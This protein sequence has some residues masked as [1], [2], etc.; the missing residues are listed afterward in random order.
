MNEAIDLIGGIQFNVFDLKEFMSMFLYKEVFNI[1]RVPSYLS[2]ITEGNLIKGLSR[3]G[4]RVVEHVKVKSKQ[5]TD[6]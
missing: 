5:G 3:L 2:Y 4:L 1:Y 6:P